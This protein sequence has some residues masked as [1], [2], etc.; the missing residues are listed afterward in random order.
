MMKPNKV[1][2][3][4]CVILKQLM[5]ILPNLQHWCSWV[6]RWTDEI[7][8]WKGDSETTCGQISS[9]RGIFSPVYRMQVCILT[10][11]SQLLHMTLMT[12]LRSWGQRSR[13]GRDSIACKCDSSWTRTYTYMSH[14]QAMGAERSQKCSLVRTYQLTVCHGRLSSCFHLTSTVSLINKCFHI[15][16]V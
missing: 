1:L 6:Q 4:E 9:L 8:R 15:S 11:S 7:L 13:S 12:F 3:R 10:K 14:T 2:P 5:G 16:C